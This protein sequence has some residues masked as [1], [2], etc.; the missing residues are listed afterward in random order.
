MT[1]DPAQRLQKVLARAGCGSRRVCEELI[2]AGR[3]TVNGRT[4]VLGDRADAGTDEI[5]L[6]GRVLPTKPDSVYVLLHKPVGVVSTASDTHDRTTVVELVDVEH[7]LF[8]VGRLD[9]DSE[10]LIILTN[11]G[12]LAQLM[13]H[14]SHGVEKEYLVEVRSGTDG[15]PRRALSRLRAGVEL[16]DG[17]TRPATVSQPAPGVLRIVLQEGRNRQIRRMCDAVGCPVERLV[18]VRIGPVS[19]NRLVA[20]AWRHLTQQEVRAL[21]AAAEQG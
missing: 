3:V 8:P 11:D 5:R 20:G 6:D 9:M 18:R 7:R 16:D 13:T 14:P 15:V 4:A 17:P 19:D 2:E 10:G 21:Y 1:Q 12:A